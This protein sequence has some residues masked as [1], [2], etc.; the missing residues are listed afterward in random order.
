MKVRVVNL[1]NR[2]NDVNGQICKINNLNLQNIS[3][4]LEFYSVL[5]KESL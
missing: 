1:Q 3:T 4:E 2:I 5:R